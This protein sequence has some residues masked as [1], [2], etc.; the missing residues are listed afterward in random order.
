MNDTD[1]TQRLQT[2]ARQRPFEP[3]DLELP[4]GARVTID[5]PE[6][7]AFRGD[8]VVYIDSE[9]SYTLFDAG[10]VR[11]L[12]RGLVQQHPSLAVRQAIAA[13]LLVHLL[14]IGGSVIA[15]T[16]QIESIVGTGPAFSV[17]GLIVA[18]CG[19]R[20][21][22]RG[23]FWVGS[24]TLVLSLIVFGLIY[25][26]NWSPDEAS[27][28]VSVML[29]AYE[30]VTV[31]A[32]LMMLWRLFVPAP[33]DTRAAWQFDLKSMLRVT[34]LMA[35]A[36]AAGRASSD[37]GLSLLSAIAVGFLVGTIAALGW[38]GYRGP[39]LWHSPDGQT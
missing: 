31:P 1:F 38:M 6:A 2:S 27:I 28:P 10:G 34:C 4:G 17:L 14:G 13:L 3:F 26:A 20:C 37:Q 22:L 16:V 29:L 9:G 12:G 18:E 39:R 30:A 15:A 25:L 23:M 24:S 19:R 8:A 32:G 11:R 35:I 5:N 36:L 7:V 33:S 21:R